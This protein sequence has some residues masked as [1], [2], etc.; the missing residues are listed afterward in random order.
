MDTF[1]DW[2]KE[3]FGQFAS[4]SVVSQAQRDLIQAIWTTLLDDEFVEAYANGICLLF[5]DGIERLIF[6]RILTYSADYPEK[7]VTLIRLFVCFLKYYAPQGPPRMHQISGKA[8][9]FLMLDR[10]RRYPDTWNRA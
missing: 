6:P 8:P 1:Q 10:N 7:Y 3:M 2:Y 9:M 5:P 4:A